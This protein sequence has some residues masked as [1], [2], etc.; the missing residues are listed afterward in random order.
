MN[1]QVVTWKGELRK[2]WTRKAWDNLGTDKYG[3]VEE[4]AMPKELAEYAP[5]AAQPT[6]TEPRKRKSRK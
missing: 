4:P 1:D 2:V 5:Q 6:E 3:W